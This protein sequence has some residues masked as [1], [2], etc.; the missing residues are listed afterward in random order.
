MID[1]GVRPKS[2]VRAYLYGGLSGE[3]WGLREEEEGLERKYSLSEVLPHF[4]TTFCQKQASPAPS[5]DQHQPLQSPPSG[6]TG[7]ATNSA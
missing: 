5:V 4:G 2:R 1:G 7:Y 3:E 6:A